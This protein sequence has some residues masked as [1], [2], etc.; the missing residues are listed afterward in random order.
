[1]RAQIEVQR[2]IVQTFYGSA[3]IPEDVDPD[4]ADEMKDWAYEEAVFED[5]WDYDVLDYDAFVQ[6]LE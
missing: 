4:D 6:V 2:T 3:T 1:M 5:S